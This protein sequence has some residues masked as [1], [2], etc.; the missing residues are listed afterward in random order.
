MM[1]VISIIL[2]CYNAAALLPETLASL[3]AQTLADFECIAIDDGSTDATRAVLEAHA[4]RDPRFIVVSREN[5][6]LIATLNEAIALARGEWIARMDA[7]D[8]ARPE[9]LARQ[10]ARLNETGADVCGVGIRF[11]G[12]RDGIW[13]PPESDAALKAAL[14]F[15]PPFAHPGVV[16]RAALFKAHG[17]DAG[18]QHAEDYALWCAF[19]RAGARF[20]GIA[21]PLLD[22]RVHPGQITQTR[23]AEMAATG[24]AI[25]A[26]YAHHALPTE[27]TDTDKHGFAELAAPDRALDRSDWFTFTAQLVTLA[28]RDPATRPAFCTVWLDALVR[29]HGVDWRCKKRFSLLSQQLPPPAEERGKWQRQRA[30]VLAGD[31]VYGL[32]KK[33]RG[34]A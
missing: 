10:L 24:A 12:E 7:D 27:W 11:F 4:A 19:A 14:L 17:Y 23:R 6:G 29:T 25:R 26:D 8:I 3:S 28:Q 5:R 18:A 33:L 1:P 13:L 9:R 21:E 2:P 34:R 22:Y 30:R 16:A 20:T 15:N 31:A 32:I